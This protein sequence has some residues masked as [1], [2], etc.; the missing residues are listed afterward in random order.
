MSYVSTTIKNV[1]N[2][3]KDCKYILPDIQRGYVW[4]MEQIENLFDSLLRGY[5][6]NS[7]L[8]WKIE[9]SN[10]KDYNFYVFIK[11]Y[12]LASTNNNI[13]NPAGITEFTA[14]LDGQQRLTSLYIG[15]YGSYTERKK[16]VKKTNPNAFL[17]KY[18]Y[19]NL[20][21]D[22][23]ADEEANIKKF[24]FKFLSENDAKAKGFNEQNL[25]LK[26]NDIIEKSISDFLIE[27]D[28]VKK[29]TKENQKKVVDLITHFQNKINE[30]Q[31]I[32]Y[33]EEREQDLDKVLNIFVR[34]NSGG[35]QLSYSDLLMSTV[36]ATW[37]NKNAREEI[38]KIVLD[39]NNLGFCITK[40]FVMKASLMLTD[41][42]IKFMVKNFVKMN[43]QKIENEW[44]DIRKYLILTFE[45]LHKYGYNNEYMSSYNAVLPIAYYLKKRN[46]N[47]D[48]FLNKSDKDVNIIIHWLRIAFI[49]QVFGGSSDGTLTRYREIIKDNSSSTFPIKEIEKKFK[50]R[51]E[52]I[53]FS[54]E[55]IIEL[56]DN[57]DYSDKK[58]LFTV[59]SCIYIPNI[60]EQISIDH[61]YS[62]SYFGNE[63]N[64][65][66]LGFDKGEAFDF[67]HNIS[68]LQFLGITENIEKS[69]MPYDKWIIQKIEKDK[70]YKTYNLIPDMYNY[71]PNTFIDFCKKRR[72]LMVEALF[73]K[74]SKF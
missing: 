1:I 64:I 66:S 36:S 32:N 58:K 37:E 29:L 72:E 8:F 73:K 18:L 74:L 60:N 44:G 13:I 19:L 14:I 31:V 40:D 35:T 51:R 53:I 49:K 47:T 11:D 9:T 69:N 4:K 15:L 48:N 22:E 39:I 26:A 20:L 41:I 55:D 50:G 33:Y 45:I 61:M 24:G 5:P 52:D 68:N 56:V 25:W 27:N 54:M 38:E 42:D 7:F 17:K 10:L 30:A 67:V 71:E 34:V 23:T 6:I 46:A 16:G 12:S 21:Y 63:K 59:L 62:K 57:T 28:D 65:N 3:I 43:V 2:D 70:S